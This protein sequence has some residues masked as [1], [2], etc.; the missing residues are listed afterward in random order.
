MFRINTIPGESARRKGY[1]SYPQDFPHLV[2]GKDF[3]AWKVGEDFEI[4]TTL[5][6]KALEAR[7]KAFNEEVK[8]RGRLQPI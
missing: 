3:V 1:A 7:L 4:E 2:P 5:G 8:V 6:G